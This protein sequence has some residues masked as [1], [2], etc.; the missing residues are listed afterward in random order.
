MLA[1]AAG[2]LLSACSD[3]E[4]EDPEAMTGGMP[5]SPAATGGMRA[6]VPPRPRE[7]TTHAECSFPLVCVGASCELA[8]S[9]VDVLV[10]LPVLCL[11]WEDLADPASPNLRS[12]RLEVDGGVE[13]LGEPGDFRCPDVRELITNVG[14]E[15]T[16]YQ[17]LC[18]PDPTLVPQDDAGSVTGVCCYGGQ[19]VA[20]V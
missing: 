6:P 10:D 4:P 17:P 15:G 2:L 7:C 14:G 16:G 12:V 1:V 8:R 9:C 5:A 20:G 3:D 19:R 18:G 13:A 11:R